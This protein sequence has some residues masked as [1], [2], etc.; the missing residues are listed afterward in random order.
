M[1]LEIK[2]VNISQ[3]TLQQLDQVKTQLD[4]VG[5]TVLWWDDCINESQ[6]TC[7]CAPFS[8]HY[9]VHDEL[10]TRDRVLQ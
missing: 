8:A 1:G 9:C 10:T 5:S 6:Y 2:E 4:E 3:L 7:A